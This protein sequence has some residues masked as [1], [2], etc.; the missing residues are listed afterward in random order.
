MLTLFLTLSYARTMSASHAVFTLRVHTVLVSPVQ[1]ST[2]LVNNFF[3]S[4]HFTSITV[5]HFLIKCP[6]RRF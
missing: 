6:Y 5:F 2:H 1:T 3:Y 4:P